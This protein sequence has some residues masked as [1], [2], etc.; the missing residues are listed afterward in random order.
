VSFI[1]V[2]TCTINADQSGSVD[3]KAAPQVQQSFGVGQAAQTISFDSTA[4]S[5][6]AAGGP[7][8]QVMVSAT[9]GLAVSVAIDAG[10]T[11]VCQLSGSTTGSS[12]SFIGAG[13]CKINAN[14]AGDA[15]HSAATPAQQ[16]FAVAPG[17]PASLAFTTQPTA[18]ITVGGAL[19]T[20]AVTEKDAFGDVIDD[21]ASVVDFTIAL[22][23]GFDLG[24]A[25]MSHGVA[26]LSSSQHFYTTNSYQISAKTGALTGT[27]ALFSVQDVGSNLVFVEGFDGCHP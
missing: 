21:S 7:T 27:S 2:G 10:S 12:V 18:I 23:G 14:Q 25:T 9:S 11:A 6:A 8:Y 20:I 17:P 26:T 16:S 4:P 22:C 1:G 5:T 15:N 3:Y 13:T 24:S 19:G